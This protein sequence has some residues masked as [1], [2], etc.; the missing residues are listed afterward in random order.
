M[1]EATRTGGRAA[2]GGVIGG[3][4]ALAVGNPGTA[5]PTGFRWLPLGELARL[6]TGH[7]P[8]R[9]HPEYWDGGIPWIG[10]R[11]ATENHGRTLFETKQHVSQ[12]GVVNSSTRLLPA[13]TVCLSRTASVGYVVTMGVPMCTSQDFVNWVCG[14]GLD[15]RYLSL[16][17]Q[18]EQETVRRFASG[19][20][21][22]TV[23]FPEAKAFHIAAPDIAEQ[24]AI[25]ATLG[26][27]DDKIESNR[28]SATLA[29][30]L[31]AALY[32]HAC[33]VASPVV[34]VAQVATFHNSTRVPLSSRERAAMPGPVPYYGA[35]GIVDHVAGALFDEILLL[36]GED[37]TV[38]RDEGGP[39]T[40][41]IWG[42][43]WVNNHAH[44]LTGKTISTELLRLALEDADVRPLVTGAVQ[45]KLNMGNLKAL[46][47]S[48]PTGPE[49]AALEAEL[50]P[51]FAVVRQR[52]DESRRVGALRNALLPELLSGRIRASAMLQNADLALA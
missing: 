34:P 23:Y 22:Q 21:H 27:L 20:T 15:H 46:K 41:Y 11:D 49:L 16:V 30:S 33:A 4:T 19:T 35:T 50:A 48:L 12:L 3:G 47:L 8:S 32:R 44:V 9:R 51:L 40:Q 42:P 13:G 24:R 2:T 7:T 45:A 52:L 36:V 28:R 10:I 43:C 25:A 6:E 37:G 26:A 39:V 38:I 1:A 31:A 14:E 18:L 17:L 29:S 5:L